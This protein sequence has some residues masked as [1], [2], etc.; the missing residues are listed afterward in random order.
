MRSL[1]LLA[2]WLAA[3]VALATEQPGPQVVAGAGV[4]AL[5]L[6]GYRDRRGLFLASAAIGVMALAWLRWE[7]AT[8]PPA[9]DSIAWWATGER[10]TVEGRIT[11]TPEIR[12]ASQRFVVAVRSV[13]SGG[14]LHEITGSVQVRVSA[15]RSYRKGDL[16]RLDGAV[17]TPP[18]LD[19]FDY[20]AYLA[21]RGIYAVMEY[22]RLRVTG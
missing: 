5:S 16:V 15:S 18:V 9:A 2:A 4:V 12:G 10:L 17:E 13:R 6:L 1:I 20:G 8:R 11:T 22:P 21:R 19:D 7:A 3:L 14:V